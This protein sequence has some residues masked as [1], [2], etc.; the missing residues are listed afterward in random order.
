MKRMKKK[1]PS[2]EKVSF[3]FAF[4]LKSISRYTHYK[5]KRMKTGHGGTTHG[6]RY[7]NLHIKK[8]FFVDYYKRKRM[9]TGH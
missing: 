8:K 4:K 5:R 6:Q 2:T 7:L 9:K 1:I 3:F